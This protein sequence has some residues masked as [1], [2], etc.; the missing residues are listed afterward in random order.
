MSSVA[1]AQTPVPS[2]RL[3]TSPSLVSA[4]LWPSVVSSAILC[5]TGSSDE[6]VAAAL[7]RSRKPR[8]MSPTDRKHCAS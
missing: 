4:Y 2:H 8:T 1:A 3:R 7:T 5:S 6:A